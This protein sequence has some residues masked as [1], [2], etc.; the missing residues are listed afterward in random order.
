MTLLDGRELRYRH[1]E[2]S[3]EAV[4][5]V[6]IAVARGE[7]VGVIGP[8][9][10][11]KSTLARISCG[12]LPAQHGALL[13][14]GAPMAS[15]SR[16]ERARRVAFLPQ[17]PPHD[18]SFT[19][20]EVALM[21]RA[22]HLGLWSLEGPHDLERANAALSEVDALDLADRPV[23]QLSG[24]ERQRVFLARAFAQEAALLV[25]D[26]PTAALDLAHQVLL[27]NALRR[28]A[29]EGGGALLVLHDLALAGAACDRLVLMHGGRVAAEG[30]PTDVLRPAV[31]EPV[32]GTEV[33]V[34]ADPATG[35]PLVAP[36]ISR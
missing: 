22:P 25:L 20:R 6:S 9:A 28:R 31:L 3:F 10:A 35:Q 1:S 29:R 23:S 24:G 19:A 33:E 16:R 5:G 18:L 7:V 26:E 36:R 27:V 11:G 14:Q 32:Y 2:A 13:L 21:G 34:M 17:H 30:P 12:L 15:L 8:N 4:A